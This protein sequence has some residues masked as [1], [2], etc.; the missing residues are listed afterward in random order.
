MAFFSALSSMLESALESVADGINKLADAIPSPSDTSSSSRST[1]SSNVQVQTSAR[2][3][4]RRAAERD[5]IA[6]LRSF[7]RKHQVEVEYAE[8]EELVK[9]CSL[10]ATPGATEKFADRFL[11]TAHM[12]ATA[13]QIEALNAEI[14]RYEDAGKAVCSLTAARV[15]TPGESREASGGQGEAIALTHRK[16]TPTGQCNCK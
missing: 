16:R 3:A 12:R 5:S 2:E 7:F 9:A 10:T 14:A 13:T 11:Q 8:I 6:A 4:L 15:T 1:S